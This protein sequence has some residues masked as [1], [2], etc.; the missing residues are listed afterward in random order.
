MLLLLLGRMELTQGMKAVQQRQRR[1]RRMKMMIH[2]TGVGHGAVSRLLRRLH[3]CLC[4]RW[5]H[6]RLVPNRPDRSDMECLQ[7]HRDLPIYLA[8][9]RMVQALQAHRGIMVLMAM[10][11]PPMAHPRPVPAVPMS[12]LQ[13]LMVH[14]LG[15]RVHTAQAPGLTGHQA[16][17][18]Q[19][20]NHYQYFRGHQQVWAP[21]SPPGG[22]HQ[23]R[24][25]VW[26]QPQR[27]LLLA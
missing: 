13:D 5:R 14:L 7:D 15:R 25:T 26:P 2:Q 21:E 16:R 20:C 27:Q 19:A 23:Q 3:Q 1:R 22:P 24:R 12:L 11:Q 17:Y 18:Q 10:I 9:P 4:H 6:L 8:Q